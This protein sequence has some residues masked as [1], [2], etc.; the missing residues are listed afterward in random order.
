M[1]PPV[2]IRLSKRLADSDRRLL[3]QDGGVLAGK[4][5]NHFVQV[6]RFRQIVLLAP[7]LKLLEALVGEQPRG[8]IG[9]RIGEGEADEAL[10]ERRMRRMKVIGS[11][12]GY[13]R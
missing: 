7:I 4:S 13:P 1:D 11:S 5:P 6:Q 2:L 9:S 8:Q 12:L 3:L 10:E